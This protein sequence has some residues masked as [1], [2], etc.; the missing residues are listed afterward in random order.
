LV[1]WL[2]CCVSHRLWDTPATASRVAFELTSTFSKMFMLIR[3][4]A[5]CDGFITVH[6][7]RKFFVF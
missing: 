3:E 1:T 5:I 7:L 2:K 4:S 6:Q